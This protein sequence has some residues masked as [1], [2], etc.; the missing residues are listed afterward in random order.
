LLPFGVL[1]TWLVSIFGAAVVVDW[2]DSLA[3]W[4]EPV[5]DAVALVAAGAIAAA[6]GRVRTLASPPRTEPLS[7]GSDVA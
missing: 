7:V 1:A 4:A 3:G 6:F 2:T 5:A